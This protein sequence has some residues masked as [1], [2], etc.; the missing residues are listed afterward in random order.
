VSV[1]FDAVFAVFVLAM[2]VI[3]VLAV[4]WGVSRDRA[5]RRR[6]AEGP[7]SSGT[8]SPELSAP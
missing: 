5:E 3:G 4:R 2:V 8:G 1:L 6:R 7:G